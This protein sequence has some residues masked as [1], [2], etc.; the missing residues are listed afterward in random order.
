MKTVDPK[1]IEILKKYDSSTICNV[2][3]VAKL[4]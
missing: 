4:C 2:K 3:R 1:Y